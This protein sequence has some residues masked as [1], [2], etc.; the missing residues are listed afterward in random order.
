MTESELRHCV[1]IHIEK[2]DTDL[3]HGGDTNTCWNFA[4]RH[5][6]HD[7][8]RIRGGN[9]AFFPQRMR[10]HAVRSVAG[11]DASRHPD[12]EAAANVFTAER[13]RL[14]EGIPAIPAQCAA[15]KAEGG[16]DLNMVCEQLR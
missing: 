3:R 9:T 4:K 15:P 16:K 14:A 12:V 13:R 7:K 10:C 1:D 5:R 2:A 11:D 6:K 8:F